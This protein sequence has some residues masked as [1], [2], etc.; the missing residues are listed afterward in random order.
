MG[1]QMSRKNVWKLRER[2]G[3]PILTVL[4]HGG[5]HFKTL[6]LEDG[7][8]AELSPDG[9]ITQRDWGHDFWRND[10]GE[11]TCRP[12]PCDLCG[13]AHFGPCGERRPLAADFDLASRRI[14]G[15]H[16]VRVDRLRPRTCEE[17]L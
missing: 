2:L 3:L 11:V 1:Q 17:Y 13:K 16:Y 14:R 8:C 12:K 10:R 9:A 15:W 6:C 4:V 7:T 5:D